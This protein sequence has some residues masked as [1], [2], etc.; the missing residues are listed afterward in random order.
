MDPL[1]RAAAEAADAADPLAAYRDRFV[2]ED[3]RIYLDGN[4]LGRLPVATRDRLAAMAAEWG[5]RLVGGWP[6]WID[7]PVRT[8]D[9][10][11][12]LIGA[13]PG[14]VVVCDSTTVNLFKLVEA[15]LDA[16]GGGA[17]VVTDRGNFPTD[18]YVLEG[19]AA[20]RGLEL[21]LFDGEPEAATLPC[22][23]GDVVV[24]SLVGYRTGALADLAAL[25]AAARERGATLVWDLS[26]AAGAVP[27]DLR[28][29]GAELAVGCTY[30]YL[31]AGPGAPAYLCV[32]AELQQT[33]LSPIWGWF[34]QREQFA[35]ERD[36]DPEPDI[37]RF[38][39]GT[40]PI[41]GLA[42][43]EEGVRLTAEAGIGELHA[44]AIEL[45]QLIVSLHDAWLAPLGFELVSPRDPARRGSHVSLQH[46]RA[47]QITRALIERADVIPDFRGPDSVRLG[48]APLYTRH[49]DVWDALDRLRG[50]V[51]SGEHETVDA[52]PGRVT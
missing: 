17:A 49:V 29:A 47:W 42:A 46:P 2:H 45:T 26:H 31:N 9:L 43:V 10:V 22:G 27:V 28:G 15:A 11:A 8:G 34:G 44:K 23:P 32:A 16:R 21:R 7:A 12:E 40:P 4:S 5:E 20:R 24:L 13:A 38:L 48:V 37:R 35:M 36:Y 50:L 30:K 14:E 19:I 51:E 25:Q 41:L 3:E 6:D 33:L 39:A 1:S 52:T 18:R